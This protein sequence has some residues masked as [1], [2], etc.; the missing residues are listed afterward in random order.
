MQYFRTIASAVSDKLK[1]AETVSDKLKM[2]K[3]FHFKTLRPF[4][5]N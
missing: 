5:I 1:M 4:Q 2:G 3:T